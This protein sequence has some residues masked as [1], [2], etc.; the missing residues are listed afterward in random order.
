MKTS[1]VNTNEGQ[2]RE[3]TQVWNDLNNAVEMFLAMQAN[4]NASM[5]EMRLLR[6]KIEVL[7]KELGQ[8]VNNEMDAAGRDTQERIRNI[9]KAQKILN[10]NP[11]HLEA[12]VLLH[13][14]T[15]EICRDCVAD[16]E[17]YPHA[18]PEGRAL[19]IALDRRNEEV[20]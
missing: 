20:A 10:G 18:C 7:E 2:N 16:G 12:K 14:N 6:M 8:A 13:S 4:P 17:G 19:F 11:E 15:C 9:V 3:T 1:Q 5:L